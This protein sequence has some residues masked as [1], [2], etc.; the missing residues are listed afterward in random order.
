VA[1]TGHARTSGAVAGDGLPEL[2][3][4]LINVSESAACSLSLDGYVLSRNRV[5]AGGQL[6]VVPQTSPSVAPTGSTW[7][8]FEDRSK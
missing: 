5:N 1:A 4:M 6:P 7:I 3:S 2:K 8:K